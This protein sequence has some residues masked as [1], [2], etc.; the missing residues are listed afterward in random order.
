MGISITPPRSTAQAVITG[1]TLT[2][3]TPNTTTAATQWGT[4]EC[5]VAEADMPAADFVVMA[6]VAGRAKPNATVAQGDRWQL[7]LQYSLDGGSAWST[8]AGSNILGTA[9]H[10]S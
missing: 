5:V 1:V 8:F 10:A 3:T 4:E 9:S 2:D 7:D 6:W